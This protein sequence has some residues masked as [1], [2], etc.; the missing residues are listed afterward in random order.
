MDTSTGT[1]NQV[2]DQDRVEGL[3]LNGRN[4]AQLT[5]LVSGA[6]VAPVDS[7]D[8]GATKTFPVVIQVATNGTRGNQVNF[9]LDGGNNV[10]EYTN[11]N[12]PFPMPDVVQEF[13][14]QTSNYNPEYGL[15]AGGVVNIIT[16]SG[17]N[18]IHGDLFEYNRNAAFNARN[19]FSTTR[20]PLKR[21][22]YGGT[23][24]GPLTIPRLYS[25]HDKTFFFGG[26]QR[27]DLQDSIGGT[28]AFVP[29]PA[30]INN[31]DFSAL[32][33]A[34]NP[35]N[36]LGKA[37]QITTPAGA[38]YTNNQIPTASYDKA[39][40]AL[41]AYLPIS[42]GSTDGQVFYQKPT[43]VRFLEGT[44]RVDHIF[45]DKDNAM[46]RFFGDHFATPAVFNPSN[47]LSYADGVNNLATNSIATETHTFSPNLLNTARLAYIH[48]ISTRGPAANAISVSSLGVSLWQPATPSIQSISATGF[49]S[50]GDN[51][52]GSF[53]RNNYTFAND[54]HWVRGDHSLAFGGLGE[55]WKTD[56]TSQYQE[57]GAFTFNSNNTGYALA[58]FMTGYLYTFSQGNGQFFN[59]RGQYI[60]FYAQDSYKLNRRLTLNYG[61]R[62]EPYYPQR[63]L[64]RRIEEFSPAL[65]ATGTKSAIYTNSPAGLL[66]S[67]DPQIPEWGVRTRYAGFEPRIGF[68]YDLLGNGKTILRG[69]AG[70]FYDTRTIG[71]FMNSMSTSTPF[72]VSESLTNPAGPFS[73]PYLGITNPFPS[74]NPP[75]NNITFPL[76]VVAITYEPSGNYH[77]P[78]TYNYNLTVEQQLKNTLLRVAYVGSHTTHLY[79]VQELNPAVYTPGSSLG[80][81]ARR[82]YVPMS[83][84]SEANMGANT[85]YN[86]LQG[87]LQTRLSKSIDLLANYTFSKTY[88][89]LPFG[90]AVTGPSAG[91]AYAIPIYTPNYSALDRGLSDIDHKH[92]FVVSYNW[93]L[94]ALPKDSNSGMEVLRAVIGDWQTTGIFQTQSGDPLTILAGVDESKTGLGRDHGQTVAGQPVYGPG[95]C[96]A[97]AVCVNWLNPG[98]WSL[99]AVGT[100]GNVRKSSY[101]GPRYTNWD[102]GL[103]R[104]F[105]IHEALNITFRAEYFNL[106]NHTELA[107]PG[108]TISSA[109]FGSI[110]ATQGGSGGYGSF[111]IGQLA[112]KIEF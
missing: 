49:F 105:P 88:D 45:S 85:E 75:P 25:G 1:L 35:A 28:S 38:P 98:A 86:S 93:K 8:Q 34:S 106:M 100:Y 109:G 72:S 39:A 52:Q 59:N 9:L 37:V 23:I 84:V 89:N 104:V 112:L 65:W 102:G 42:S 82:L 57:P 7:A 74:P 67:G 36:P 21:N 46:V 95:A 73:N 71:V 103:Y 91:T 107:D 87:T 33:T 64:H 80:T 110:S 51:P 56:I 68:A 70:M 15:D 12:M 26:M 43:I 31:G 44:G 60:A 55:I 66:F 77:V 41:L 50:S 4:L 11:V 6:F 19:Y 17:S 24:G 29:T 61:L 69:G 79:H 108:T 10:D 54:L 30:E 20:D 22:Q 5:S 63:E 48:E 62:W 3:P 97:G 90:S 101:I 47:I 96:K 27:T 2:I 78:L 14:V 13:S 92:R 99:P 83:N 58:S 81:D 16:K 40:K 32:L 94:P 76:P 53:T 111:R 18:A